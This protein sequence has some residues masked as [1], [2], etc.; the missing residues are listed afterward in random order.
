MDQINPFKYIDIKC[1]CLTVSLFLKK[2]KKN[3]QIKFKYDA[4]IY[5]WAYIHGIIEKFEKYGLT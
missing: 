4:R 2:K 1:V 3:Q 5:A